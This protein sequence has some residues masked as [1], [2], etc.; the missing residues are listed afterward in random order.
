MLLR[1]SVHRLCM[2][3]KSVRRANH[4]YKDVSAVS[5]STEREDPRALFA[6]LGAAALSR[7]HCSRCGLDGVVAAFTHSV[8]SSVFVPGS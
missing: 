3:V 2:C 4:T 1:L 8:F 6:T 7:T 5:H